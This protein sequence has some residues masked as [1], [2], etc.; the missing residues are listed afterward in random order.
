MF[1][2]IIHCA[3]HLHHYILISYPHSPAMPV[4]L[5]R[6]WSDSLASRPHRWPGEEAEEGQRAGVLNSPGCVLLGPQVLECWGRRGVSPEQRLFGV[7]GDFRWPWSGRQVPSAVEGE[8]PNGQ[9]WDEAWSNTEAAGMYLQTLAPTL[10]LPHGG[11]SGRVCVYLCM[12]GAGEWWSVS[13]GL[14][15]MICFFVNFYQLQPFPPFYHK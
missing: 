15:A 12:S 5:S 2:V 14:S 13:I 3:F 4:W 6:K 10:M 7:H 1:Y 9:L 8:A 11:G